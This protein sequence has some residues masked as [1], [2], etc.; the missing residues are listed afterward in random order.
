MPLIVLATDSGAYWTGQS[1]APWSDA[2]HEAKTFATPAAAWKAAIDVQR[3]QGD[4]LEGA[5]VAL[6]VRDPDDPR[7]TT[8]ALSLD[9]ART[10]ARLRQHW[11][12]AFGTAPPADLPMPDGRV[13]ETS[14]ANEIV[15]GQ[16]RAADVA[17][18]SATR[19]EQAE[20]D[21]TAAASLPA[22]VRRHFVRTGERFYYRQQPD[23]LA[24]RA[25]PAALRAA[26]VSE[27]V[28][29]ALVEMAAARGWRALNVKGSKAFKQLVWA[30]A[31]T[32][33]MA[34]EGYTP[35]AG[36][37]A[38][39]ADRHSVRE[40]A[41]RKASEARGQAVRTDGR[42]REDRA[43]SANPLA[44]ELLSYGPA[45]Y[46]RQAG[47][48]PSFHV[49]LRAA[50]GQAHTHWGVDLARA[51]ER[52]GAQ[53]GDK[54]VLARHG[55]QPVTSR[56]PVRDEAGAVID[57][58]SKTVERNA[59]SLEVRER[60]AAP[61]AGRAQL[62]NPP[63]VPRAACGG[64]EAPDRRASGAS[65]GLTPIDERVGA[66]FAAR[67]LAHLSDRERAEFQQRYRV[68]LARMKADLGLPSS[69][70]EIARG[71]VRENAGRSR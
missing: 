56:A 8:R 47:N 19:D 6:H 67:R 54:V 41:S 3:R 46:R 24:F 18:S 30:A 36:E 53:I 23:K 51:M 31:T 37:R 16:A 28:A 27:S 50:D 11:R 66:A 45:P 2:A 63:Q 61:G 21:R 60:G 65:E 43:P 34:V 38:L 1:A 55:K 17:V 26:E 52:A 13:F 69:P 29:T 15:R 70:N 5:S 7:S 4:D 59:W 12:R 42:V 48:A 9:A 14:I 40:R 57:H 39:A 35:S 22:F 20:P 68:A 25:D 44:G 32:R 10:P 33:G 58:Q 62:P 49:C 64:T 71:R